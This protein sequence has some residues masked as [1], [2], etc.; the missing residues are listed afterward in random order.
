MRVK[1]PP[2]WIES[3]AVSGLNKDVARAR[4]ANFK[5]CLLHCAQL[6]FMVQQA[7]TKARPQAFQYQPRNAFA[8]L[9]ISRLEENLHRGTPPLCLAT[10]LPM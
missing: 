5:S 7:R 6:Q 9:S 1:R 3:E 4:G 10:Y 8:F 2:C